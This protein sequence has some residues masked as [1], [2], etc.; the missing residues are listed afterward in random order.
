MQIAYHKIFIRT[1]FKICIHGLDDCL[2]LNTLKAVVCLLLETNVML[3]YYDDDFMKT[4]RFCRN[5]QNDDSKNLFSVIIVILHTQIVTY[6]QQYD[7]KIDCLYVILVRVWNMPR[8]NTLQNRYCFVWRMDDD[9]DK[10]RNV[11]FMT[12]WLEC[13]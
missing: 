9:D 4:F 6:K 12:V 2:P 10:R 1:R 5:K 8:W 3:V 13:T 7:V 11:N